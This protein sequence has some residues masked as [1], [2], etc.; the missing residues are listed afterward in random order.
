VEPSS[1]VGAKQV[2]EVHVGGNATPGCSAATLGL[3]L[4]EAKSV[5]AG[6]QRHLVQAQAE[7]HCQVRRRCPRC[8]GQRP[9]KDQR[10]RQLR[11]LFGTVRGPRPAVLTR[12]EVLLLVAG[13][14]DR[15]N[16]AV[17]RR[18]GGFPCR[19]WAPTVRRDKI[20]RWN[21]LERNFVGVRVGCS[22]SA[23]SVLTQNVF[24]PV[25]A[26]TEKVGHFSASRPN[27]RGQRNPQPVGHDA[28]PISTAPTESTVQ[29][30]LHRRMGANQQMR[31][32][33][34]GAH[35]MLKVRTA[36]ANGTL[37]RDY[38]VAERWERRPFRRAA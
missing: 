25:Q 23:M 36:V 37:E 5:L 28:E 18:N 2:H 12:R 20:N 34:R 21:C 24:R 22:Q 16:S 19:I 6:L 38:A 35:M 10:P 14:S 3:S 15:S 32:S 7:E 27:S 13:F 11:L 33:P 8:G 30:L 4:A 9:L 17:R 26:I 29:W 31:W 1:T